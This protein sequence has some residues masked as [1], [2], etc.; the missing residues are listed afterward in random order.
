MQSGDRYGIDS[1]TV[2][3]DDDRSHTVNVLWFSRR[4]RAIE[5]RTVAA[6]KRMIKEWAAVE[7][8]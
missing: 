4:G 5:L 8:A 6:A 7:L 2:T 1:I 3:L